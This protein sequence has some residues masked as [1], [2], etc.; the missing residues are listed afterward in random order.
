MSRGDPSR[1]LFAAL[2]IAIGVLI[3]T[4]SGLCSLAALVILVGS[5]AQQPS[6]D[7]LQGLGQLLV[8]FLVFG[9]TPI[10]AGSALI[11]AG[12]RVG[13]GGTPAFKVDRKVF[14]TDPPA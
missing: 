8:F 7:Y 6:S 12:L 2:L 4:L 11:Y 1:R 5:A 9:G 10:A 14:D 3:V 13:R